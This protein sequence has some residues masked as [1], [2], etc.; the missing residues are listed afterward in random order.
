MSYCIEHERNS[1]V[2]MIS[3]VLDRAPFPRF[4]CYRMVYSQK[5]FKVHAKLQYR[6]HTPPLYILQYLL[7]ILTRRLKFI[8]NGI[9]LIYGRERIGLFCYYQEPFCLILEGLFWFYPP[10]P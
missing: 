6:E 2:S 9:A 4:I 3:R 10:W 7:S 5:P 8:F 1:A